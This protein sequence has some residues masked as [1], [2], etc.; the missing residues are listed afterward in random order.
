MRFTNIQSGPKGLRTKRG[1]ITVFP[2]QTVE[3]TLSDAELAIA[4]RS[5]RWS[6]ED[7][8]P[9]P[10]DRDGDGIP[11]GSMPADPPALTG[12]TKAELLAIAEAEGAGADGAMTKTAIIDAIEARR[13]ANAAG[14]PEG[15]DD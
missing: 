1:I 7:D 2:G 12:K 5:G 15:D 14:E 3:A 6:I 8:A 4:R 11:G 10:T 9:H 13:A